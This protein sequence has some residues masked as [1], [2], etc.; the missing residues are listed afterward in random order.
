MRRHGLFVFVVKKVPL[1]RSPPSARDAAESRT[2]TGLFL[3][4]SQL[5]TLLIE[6]SY[7]NEI[8]PICLF[9]RS[10]IEN[11]GVIGHF[12][13]CIDVDTDDFDCGTGEEGNCFKIV[14]DQEKP[15]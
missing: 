4:R 13:N 1:A 6:L 8:S 15:S 14:R 7:G 2:R 10:V 9:A 11:Y 3:Y 5:V 12:Q